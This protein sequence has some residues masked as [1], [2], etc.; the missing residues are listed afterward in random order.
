M[1]LSLASLKQVSERLEI[2]L[3]KGF[4]IL[5]RDLKESKR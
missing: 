4:G 3:L 1:S 5:F 2:C